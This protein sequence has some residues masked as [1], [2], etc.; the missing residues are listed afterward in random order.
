MIVSTSIRCTRKVAKNLKID[1]NN[2]KIKVKKK[3][4]T[5]IDTRSIIPLL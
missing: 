5:I 3:D 1:I 4:C 2:L